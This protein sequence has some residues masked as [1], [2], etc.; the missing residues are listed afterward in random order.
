MD[1]PRRNTRQRQLILEAVKNA[2]THP[3][4]EEIYQTVKQQCPN[5][6]LGTVYRN[7]SLLAELGEIQKLALG[8][9]CD[10]FDGTCQEHG[11]IV[12]PQCGAVE[13]LPF[14]LAHPLRT[15]LEE[16]LDRELDTISLSACGLCPKCRCKNK[17]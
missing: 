13:D 2:H 10:H 9:G 6:S 7:L 3:S 14:E 15:K 4:A 5:I 1:T 11:H 16:E 8:C 12:C 17:K